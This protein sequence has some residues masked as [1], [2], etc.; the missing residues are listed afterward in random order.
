MATKALKIGGKTLGEG[1]AT[2][3]IAEIGINHNGDVGLAKKIIDVA[4]DAGADAV[5]FQKRTVDVVFPQA[6]LDK[7]REVPRWLLEKAIERGVL[8][9]ASVKRLKATDFKDTR[10]GDQK[11]ALEFTKKEYKEIDK[12]CKEKG[13]LWFA[14][15]WDE[16]SV[17]FLEV[18]NPPAYKVAS[19]SL[20]DDGLLRHMRSKKHPIILSTGGCTMKYIRHAV[21]ILGTKELIVMQC[22]AAYP[23]V[24]SPQSLA[25]IN[26]ACINTYKKE[27]PGILI[28]FSGNDS[29]SIMAFA[30]VVLGSVA[31][32]KHL[33]LERSLWGSDQASSV[34]PPNFR[35][36]C[37]WIRDYRHA[38]GDGVKCILPEEEE[39]MKKLRRK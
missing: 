23:K 27:F 14:S 19:A 5:K 22:T 31:V 2:F 28:G 10:N 24:E 11:Y 35:T 9:K 39:A 4:V 34:E 29:G 8:P 36:M 30:A 6:D 37:R 1:E 25:A 21:K 38:L 3:I 16:A 13:I 32:E 18:F 15:P 7:P 33:T 12:Y 26:L 17:D 20:T